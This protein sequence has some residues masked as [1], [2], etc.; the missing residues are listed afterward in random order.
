MA[1]WEWLR[2]ALN[3]SYGRLLRWRSN[4]GIVALNTLILNSLGVS[5]AL[6][7]AWTL[8]KTGLGL[9][10]KAAWP[11]WVTV[12][13]TVIS[14]DLAIYLQHL[15]FHRVPILWRLHR[16]HHADLDFDVTTGA[17]FHPIEIV[18]SMGI[19][20]TVISLIGPPVLGVLAFEVI[21]NGMAM[22]NHSNITL[23]K[24]ADGLLR[25]IVVTPDMHRIH[26]SVRVRE[27]HSNYGFNL[28]WWD[29]IFRTYIDESKDKANIS[30]GLPIFRHPKYLKL[31]WMLAIPF[32]NEVPL[33]NQEIHETPKESYQSGA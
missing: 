19:K 25:L 31:R 27:T 23:P 17:R 11:L 6:A 22:F 26:H 21:L 10:N 32:M 15:L 4:L 2:P 28:S 13:M 18:L 12:P 29:R 33:P 24:I 8:E 5:S 14:M 9:L 7:Y 30:I 16:M 1:F 20:L 3:R